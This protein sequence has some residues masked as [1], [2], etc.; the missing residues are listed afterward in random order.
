MGALETTRSWHR[1]AL[2]LA[3]SWIAA[4]GPAFAVSDSLVLL[5][6]RSLGSQ[7]VIH[8]DGWAQALIEAIGIGEVDPGTSAERFALLCPD[9]AELITQAGGRRVPSRSPFHVSVELPPHRDP[10]AP[11]RA[12]FTAPAAGLYLLAVEG[13]GIQRWTVDRRPVA[14]LDPS[15]LG[16]A[17]APMLVPLRR[18]PHEI[19][20]YLRSGS[21]IEGVELTAYRPLCL[22]PAEGW[23]SGRPLTAGDQART[24]AHALGL[25]SQ[26]PQIG[27]PIELEGEAFV[28]AS[29]W[30]ARAAGSLIPPASGD[31]WATT[32][33]SPAEFTY[34]V[35]L[36]EPGLV[37]VSGRMS[38]PSPQIWSIDGRY[39]IRVSTPE[40]RFA[41]V[42]VVTL[43]LGAGQHAIRVLLA[44]G[45]RLDVLRLARLRS[46]D[47]DY[48]TLLED[49][50]F[51]V[52]APRRYVT[53]VAAE[54]SLASPDFVR[55]LYGPAGL[56][57]RILGFAGRGGDAPLSAAGIPI[58]P[59]GP[60]VFPVDPPGTIR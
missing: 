1:V 41:W 30:G 32:T 53:R 6:A 48:L 18:G 60:P 25:E 31:A 36:A 3:V 16:V 42:P 9:R 49:A 34:R 21:R 23:R 17:Y 46:S 14:H 11:L 43:S 37:S 4:V 22:A 29:D 15:A 10:R 47:A 44:R 50:E 19:T 38:G 5:P 8:H 24:L 35:R 57:R 26:L 40:S 54:M 13:V 28:A 58:A 12:T 2:A 59:L 7:R 33:G 51:A 20:A 45:S 52:A 55:R 56:G 39:R 27:E